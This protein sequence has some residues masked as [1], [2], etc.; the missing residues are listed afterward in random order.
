[1]I[2]FKTVRWKNFLS[3]GN[4]FIEIN[5][6]KNRS[7]ILLGE[8]GSGKSTLLDAISF[9]LFN[10]PFRN[11]NKNNLVNTINQKN[12]LVEVEFSI[13]KQNYLIR[14]GIK[15]TIFEI[16]CNDKLI[17]QDSHSKDY[18]QYLE[19]QILKFNY[20]SFTQIIVLGASNFT[21][22]MQLKPADRRVII[23]G[24]LDIEIFSLMNNI[25]KSKISNLKNDIQQNEFSLSLTKE[26]IELHK[27]HLENISHSKQEK[28][29]E[30]MSIIESNKKEIQKLESLNIDYEN[31]IS[32]LSQEMNFKDDVLSQIAK[33]KSIKEKLEISIKKS[34]K[35]IN[36]YEENDTCPTCTQ[37]IPD[38][39]KEIEIKK[40][41]KNIE[42]WTNGL[43]DVDSA[44]NK[45][46]D[47]MNQVKKLEDEVKSIQ[48]KILKNK[49]SISSIQKFIQKIAKET[50]E[51]KEDENASL[52]S[53]ELKNLDDELILIENNKK[54]FLM[55]RN[56]QDH[57]SSLL[58]DGGV[59]AKIIKQYLPLI[60]K[61]TNI[62]LN[63]MNFFVSFNIDEEFNES[64]K[65]RGRDNFVY[66]NFSEGEKQRI[67]LALL[68]TWRV[69][70][71][72]KNSVNTNL[73][74]L[75]EVFDSYLDINATENVLQLL[76]STM[77]KHNNIFVISHKQ[78][79]SDKFNQAINFTKVK[80]FSI[81]K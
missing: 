77:F 31:S 81:I 59:K 13:G 3:T 32:Q 62:F 46:D 54:E 35:E 2:I 15:P 16:H 78:N 71:K 26:K 75:D 6:S 33:I 53:D 58:K 19:K 29:D 23:E 80:N 20:K 67:D 1:M 43:S 63:S 21:P 41:K 61:H 65:S 69:I 52:N 37:S 48:T 10:K 40:S 44:I 57:V 39:F 22:F 4:N 55:Q 51:M 38:D 50:I 8:S 9:G 17:N 49:T 79:I 60:N 66:E 56:I 5:L 7:T 64:I 28:I 24:L 12:C 27:K 25:L 34:N 14:R 36:F 72:L 45:L 73:L 70:A 30:N 68:F 18:Q 47:K 74:I 76:N 11:I 42:E